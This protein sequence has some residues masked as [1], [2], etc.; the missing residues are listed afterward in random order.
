MINLILPP[1]RQ[2]GPSLAEGRAGR[3]P[4]AKTTEN[5]AD[6]KCGVI[7]VI[8]GVISHMSLYS[9]GAQGRGGEGEEWRSK[10]RG[11]GGGILGRGGE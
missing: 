6:E 11:R 7:S 3:F 5:I 8:V 9:R 2:L 1:A 10:R 4:L